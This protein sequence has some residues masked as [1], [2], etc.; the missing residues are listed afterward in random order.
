[1]RKE[2]RKVTIADL[3]F[4][5]T[6]QVSGEQRDLLP[7]HFRHLPKKRLNEHCA[8]TI[9]YLMPNIQFSIFNVH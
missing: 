4:S 3:F 5:H 9:E 7:G 1:M 8:L 2:L 6:V